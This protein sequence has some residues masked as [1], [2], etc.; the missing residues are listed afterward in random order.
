MVVGTPIQTNYIAIICTKV[1]DNGKIL[2]A[3]TQIVRSGNISQNKGIFTS[4]SK[5]YIMLATA[6]IKRFNTYPKR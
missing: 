6:R 3:I 1:P 5:E 2:V 4:A